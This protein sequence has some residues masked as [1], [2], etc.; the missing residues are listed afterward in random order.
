MPAGRQPGNNAAGRIGG[1]LYRPQYG[2]RYMAIPQLPHITTA[3]LGRVIVRAT[4]HA[5]RYQ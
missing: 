4:F 2:A 5:T 3:A 1:A